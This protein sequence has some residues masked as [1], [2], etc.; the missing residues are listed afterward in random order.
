MDNTGHDRDGDWKKDIDTRMSKV[1][2]TSHRVTAKRSQVLLRIEDM[3]AKVLKRV[4]T[5]DESLKEMYGN[6][7]GMNQKVESHSIATK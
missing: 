1:V 4:K 2:H 5:N 6:I 3:L 7:S